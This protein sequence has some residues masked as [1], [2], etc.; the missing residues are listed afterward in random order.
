MLPCY[1]TSAATLA[2]Q[3]LGAHVS[4]KVSGHRQK[5]AAILHTQRPWL[6]L[7]E[8]GRPTTSLSAT[9]SV[10]HGGSLRRV[11][12]GANCIRPAPLSPFSNR[13]QLW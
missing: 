11:P 3:Q 9:A 6:A 8:T 1:A 5:P 7:T 2:K 13:G 4:I 12:M 10:C